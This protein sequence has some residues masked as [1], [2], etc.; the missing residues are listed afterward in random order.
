[1]SYMRGFVL[2]QTL[3]VLYFNFSGASEE[4]TSGQYNNN[5]HVHVQNM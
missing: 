5:D 2:V 1:M 3:S 4:P